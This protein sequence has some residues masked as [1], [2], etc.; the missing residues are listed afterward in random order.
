MLR[1]S[2]ALPSAVASIVL[3]RRRQNPPRAP[4]ASRTPSTGCENLSGR[5]YEPADSGIG[6][7]RRA[8]VRI[9]RARGTARTFSLACTDWVGSQYYWGVHTCASPKKSQVF[10]LC[11]RERWPGCDAR[12][13]AGTLASPDV[14][15]IGAGRKSFF[16]S[17][18]MSRLSV[19]TRFYDFRPMAEPR[20]HT[21]SKKSD[22]KI[23]R[24]LVPG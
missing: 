24:S 9:P 2:G 5:N 10:F 15:S 12:L 21:R 16:V 8:P 13:P 14:P 22:V 1:A 17:L 6:A 23:Y 18:G 4:D 3:P 11:L 20:H 7:F 19:K